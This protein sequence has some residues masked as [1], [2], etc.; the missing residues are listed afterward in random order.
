MFRTALISMFI[1]SIF[2][3]HA[4]AIPSIDSIEPAFGEIGSE[5]TI[6]GS[7]FSPSDID[8]AVFFFFL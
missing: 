5:I 7:N 3:A 8:N 6:T 2:N 4:W 1:M